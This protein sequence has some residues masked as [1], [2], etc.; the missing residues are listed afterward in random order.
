MKRRNVDLLHGPV[1]GKLLAFSV[2]LM[3]TQ[4]LQTL[5]NSADSMI[6]GRWGGEGALASVGSS[7]VLNM[8]IICFFGGLAAGVTV[9]AATDWGAGDRE[10][11][12]RTAHTAILLAFL[13]GLFATVLFQIL[14]VPVMTAMNVPMDIRPGAIL[15]FRLYLLVIPGQL[16]Y[17][18]G[19]GIMRA[20]GDSQR[21]LIFLT[22]AGV[23]NVCLNLLFVIVFRWGVFGVGIATVITQYLSAVLALIILFRPGS[24]YGMH[25]SRLRLHKDKVIRI[26]RVGLPAGLQASMLAASDI[27]LQSCVNSLGS[28]A[29]AGNAA[30]LNL[31]GFTFSAMMSLGQGCMVFT[32]QCVG[33]RDFHRARKVL[34][35]GMLMI[36]GIGAVVGWICV[37]FRTQLVGLFQPG[38]AAAIAFG[39]QRVMAVCSL[40]FIYGFLESMN[41]SLRGY[42]VSMPQAIINGLGLFG[43]RTLWSIFYFP[44]HQDLFHLYL[45]YPVAW[46]LCIAAMASI[47]V[48]MVRKRIAQITAEDAARDAVPADS[49]SGGALPENSGS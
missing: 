18:S 22:I 25:F 44:H 16:V 31:D 36:V 48:P 49:G 24:E 45:S 38:N 42:S 28:L 30:A 11:F 1:L 47:Y 46:T 41:S 7:F 37:L 2:P 23:C 26:V 21:P 35:N 4:W 12:D 39:E 3:L 32:G 8:L 5:F 40:A 10:S 20:R 15:Y 13:V 19:A 14:T 34:L 29:V 17:N 6:V 27:P 9:C 33:A 43:F